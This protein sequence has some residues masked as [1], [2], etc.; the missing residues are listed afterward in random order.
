MKIAFKFDLTELAK[1]SFVLFYNQ[2]IS[3]QLLQFWNFTKKYVR[4]HCN[5]TEVDRASE[6]HLELRMSQALNTTLSNF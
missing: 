1:I 5:S 4:P 6:L 3:K 2:V